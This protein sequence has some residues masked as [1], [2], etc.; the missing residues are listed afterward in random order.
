M[1]FATLLGLIVGLAMVVGSI[2]MGGDFRLFLDLH[3]F[4]I[5]IGGSLAAVCINFTFKQ[6]Y[7]AFQAG[8]KIFMRPDTN[9]SQIVDA[10]VRI[11][12]ISRREGII[13][14]EKVQTNN[15]ILKKACMLIADNA[16]SNLIKDT[17]LIEIASL[18]KRHFIAQ[19]V[20]KRLSLLTP[21]LGLMGTLIG[22]VQMFSRLNDPKT[23]G[24]AMS[25]AMLATFYGSML[26]TL[27]FQPISGKLAS[28]TLQEQHQ[29]EI[30]FEGA[31]SILENNNPRL[32]YEKLSSFV[33]PK[34]RVYA[35]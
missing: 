27:F 8:F 34:D 5:V 19:N 16:D 10:M 6:V 25:V 18:N 17:L 26:S 29:L 11:A 31:K 22:L 15:A 7:Q 35:R 9:D 21:S 1:D 28:Q 32:V 24:P 4:M 2:L 12:E 30:I 14:L 33:A 23:I 3:A 20:F 13:A